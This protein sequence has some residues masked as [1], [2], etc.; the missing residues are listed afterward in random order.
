MTQ[1][2]FIAAV[3]REAFESATKATVLRPKGQSMGGSY[4]F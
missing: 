1:E 4:S 2:E 3:S